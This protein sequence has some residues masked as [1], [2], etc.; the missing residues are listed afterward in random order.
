MIITKAEI[1]GIHLRLKSPF[2][3]SYGTYD[4]MPS[5]I[6]RLETDD[7]L[8]GYGEGVPDE[9]V[10]GETFYST[11]EVL[12]HQLL[13]AVM[14][15]NPFAIEKIHQVMDDRIIANPAAKAAVDIACYDLMGKYG[16]QP[17]Y[18]LIGGKFHEEL[19]YAKVLSI[20][21]PE[22]MAEKARQAAAV[23]YQS[24]K[25][26]VGSNLLK[27]IERIKSVRQA[28]GD[29][30]PIR[31]DVNQ[32]WENYS[33][34]IQAIQQLGSL[35]ISWIEQPI[36]MGDIDGLAELKKKSIIPI[37]ADETIHHGL[38]LTEIIKKNAADK[39]N[40]KLM[41]CGGI[42]PAVHLAKTAEYAGITCQIGSMVESSIGSAA[43]YHTAIARKNITS[44]ELTG[45]LLFSED[46]GDLSF[47][48]PFVRLNEKSGL[49]I[50][51]REDTLKALTVKKDVVHLN[52]KE[53]FL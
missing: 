1:I 50:N 41:K 9:H 17:V 44:T 15:E 11:F 32:G 47:D 45:P 31:V 42:Y 5:L 24:L 29:N 8:V 38:H 48:I 20:E 46:I 30:M 14:G 22:I 27:D 53:S 10:T 21:E 26:K 16:N 2:I 19:T 7:G 3:I 34:A 18:N 36:K 39:I 13:P 23:G 52:T 43:G 4:Y 33:T 35:H 28:V 40:I 12:K 25:L 49:G 51:V 6:V 37:M